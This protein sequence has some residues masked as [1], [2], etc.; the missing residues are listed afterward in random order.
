[1][2]FGRFRDD[3]NANKSVTPEAASHSL[4]SAREAFLS[5]GSKIVGNLNFIGPAEVDGQVDGEII[6]HDR[7]S[8]GESAI[9]NAKVSGADIT[10]RGV[11]N[12]D[13]SA[14]RRVTLKKP[15]RIQGSIVSPLL[16][17]E[18]GVLFEGKVSMPQ[19]PKSELAE[20]VTELKVSQ[21]E[22]KPAEVNAAGHGIKMSGSKG[23]GI[24]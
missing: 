18:D 11:V 4:G 21:A 22:N 5:K 10:I 3:V 6:A 24:F 2:S 9:V 13:I 12:G 16:S 17:I 7:L 8:I 14:S 15:A 20:K 23:S 19:P 1:M